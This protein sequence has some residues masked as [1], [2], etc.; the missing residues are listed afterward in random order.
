MRPLLFQASI[1]KKGISLG[2]FTNAFFHI[3]LRR[4]ENPSD[5]SLRHL[6]CNRP[7]LCTPRSLAPCKLGRF[8]LSI[9]F[10][11]RVVHV[12]IRLVQEHACVPLASL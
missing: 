3:C 11:V 6:W 9:P 10:C 8:D 1:K 7:S 2:S 5:Y 12:K 4:P